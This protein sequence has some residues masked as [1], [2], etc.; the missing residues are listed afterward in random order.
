MDALRIMCGGLG[1][2][3]S[4]CRRILR[5]MRLNRAGCCRLILY[6]LLMANL[7]MYA[8]FIPRLWAFINAEYLCLTRFFI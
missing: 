7:V 8:I 3:V 5:K 4:L 6:G 2:K 1:W